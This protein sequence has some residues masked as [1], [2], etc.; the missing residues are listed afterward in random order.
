MSPGG[1]PCH[2]VPARR[3]GLPG[4]GLSGPCAVPAGT[5]GLERV[6]GKS[7]VSEFGF[8]GAFFFTASFFSSDAEWLASARPGVASGLARLVLVW[9]GWGQ[10]SWTGVGLVGVVLG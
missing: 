3:A 8:R 5:D 4:R 9:L 1:V 2:E 10:T 7:D 6:W